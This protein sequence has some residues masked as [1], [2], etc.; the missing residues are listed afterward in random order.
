MAKAEARAAKGRSSKGASTEAL[1]ANNTTAAGDDDDEA[2]GDEE[3]Q[4]GIP[5]SI[6]V[7]GATTTG[8]DVSATTAVKRDLKAS[9]EEA[10]SESE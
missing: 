4:T 10:G 7:E 8:T 2:S 6:T 3:E 9:V 1:V 5:A